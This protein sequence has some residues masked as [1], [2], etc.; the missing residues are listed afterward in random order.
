MEIHNF[1]KKLYKNR[2]KIKY[3]KKFVLLSLLFFTLSSSLL[4][5]SIIK[6]MSVQFSDFILISKNIYVDPQMKKTEYAHI[7]SLVHKAK[8]RIV[9]KFG[10][11]KSTPVIIFTS[12]SK[13]AKKYG[14]NDFGSAVRLPWGQ[15][16]VFGSKGQNIDIIA[17][18]LLHSEIGHRLGYVTTQ[19]KLPVWIDEGV[20]MQVDYRKKYLINF[21]SLNQD[22]IDKV[23]STGTS[24]IINVNHFFSG[25]KEQVI[26][27]YQISKVL[28]T[29]ILNQNSNLSLYEMLDKAKNGE[30][31]EDVFS[32]QN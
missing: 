26:K 16:V 15:Y 2:G 1:F 20:A 24:Q 8:Q 22:E 4:Y 3:M 23:I 19:F 32:I 14:T 10:S 25:T 28:I 30:K 17:H 13:M 5:S 27:N 31:F 11:F 21:N 18:E 9:D 7:I 12:S 6:R 29:K